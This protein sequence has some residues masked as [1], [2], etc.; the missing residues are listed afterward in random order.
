MQK[1]V[2]LQ[3][4]LRKG[5][6]GGPP[7][8]KYLLI[9]AV[10]LVLLVLIAPYLFKGKNRE[11]NKRP[12]PDRA[13]ITKEVPRPVEPPAP[14]NIPEQVKPEPAVAPEVQPAP[15][16]PE[17]PPA[18]PP[19]AVIPEPPPAGNAFVPENAPPAPAP[20]RTARPAEPAP[21]DLFPKKSAPSEGP[22]AAVRKA[23]TAAVLK[24]PGKSASKAACPPLWAKPGTSTAKG[25]FAIMVGAAYKNKAEAEAVRKDLAR[26][27]YSATVRTGPY[28][29]GY[30]VVTS[31]CP[32]R[33]AYTL[34]EQMKIQG[35]SNTTIIRVAPAQGPVR[36]HPPEKP[37]NGKTGISPAPGN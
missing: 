36:K 15:K 13:S 27:G 16:P 17:L 32:E 31:P 34:Q 14:E 11:I 19:Q 25:D 22:T 12:V 1:K 18:T 26:K 9:S 28:G 20:A 2:F 8:T 5:G 4:N 10:C 37:A 23:P 35:V 7:Y 29:C 21:R 24:A 33:K 30:S 3:R 6:G